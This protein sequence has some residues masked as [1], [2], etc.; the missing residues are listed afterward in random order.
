MT[1]LSTDACSV[2]QPRSICTLGGCAWRCTPPPT[3][4]S[5]GRCQYRTSNGTCGA[6]EATSPTPVPD[7][8][9]PGLANVL[10]ERIDAIN[11]LASFTLLST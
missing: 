4:Q 10:H 1:V 5:H 2:G 7:M 3:W 6:Q 9:A 11:T 8:P